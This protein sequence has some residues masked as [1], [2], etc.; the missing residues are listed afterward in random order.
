MN[1]GEKLKVL[2]EEKGMSMNTLANMTGITY[3]MIKK[4]CGSGAE[5]TVS[6]AAKIADVLEISVDELICH[7]T[8]EKKSMF[9]EVFEQDFTYIT[10][11]MRNVRRFGDK[12]AVIDPVTERTW[13]YAQ[14]NEDVNQFANA[15]HDAGIAKGDVILYQMPNSIEYI[16]CYLAPQKLG[17]INSPANYNFSPV[18]SSACMNTSGPKVYLYESSLK[19]MAVKALELTEKKPE[20]V[21][22]TGEGEVPEGHIRYEDF[23]KGYPKTEPIVDL[24]LIS[25]M[26]QCAFTH[27]ERPA[28]RKP[29]RLT[30]QL[31]CFPRMTF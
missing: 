30:M 27:P 7:E 6:Y 14:L 19:D 24:S 25:M 23:V 21:I 10:G 8:K 28:C 4:Y 11:F 29:F 12:C 1:F 31:K 16:Y 15:L 5:P 26:R 3:N 13:T 22:M 18:E 2:L 9:R 17:A 20:I